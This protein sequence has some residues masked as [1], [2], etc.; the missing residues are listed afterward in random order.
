MTSIN[1]SDL[2]FAALFLLVPINSYA[3]IKIILGA[4]YNNHN[5]SNYYNPASNY[6]Q[7]HNFGSNR[8]PTNPYLNNNFSYYA[9]QN[10]HNKKIIT[11]PNVNY[12]YN[13]DYRFNNLNPYYGYNNLNNIYQKA[14]RQGYRDAKR[15]ERHKNNY[16]TG[17]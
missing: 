14:Y 5:Y 10:R 15:H 4:P 12:S 13:P 3:D 16:K 6:A 7:R 9:N 2:F 8:F 17:K 1:K 11:Y